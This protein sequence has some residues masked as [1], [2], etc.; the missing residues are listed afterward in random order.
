MLLYESGFQALRPHER[1][2]KLQRAPSGVD[3]SLSHAPTAGEHRYA[4]C[5][6]LLKAAIGIMSVASKLECEGHGSK[7]HRTCWEGKRRPPAGRPPH[8]Q[9]TSFCCIRSSQRQRCYPWPQGIA[10]RWRIRAQDRSG[11]KASR[12]WRWKRRTQRRRAA[13][14]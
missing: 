9:Q 1:L 2:V 5:A 13:A 8:Q 11:R 12:R 4:H 7:R 10:G 3:T 6:F 14:W